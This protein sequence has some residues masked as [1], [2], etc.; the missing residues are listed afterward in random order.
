MDYKQ[1]CFNMVETQLRPWNIMSPQV[2]NVMGNT[3]REKFVPES[4][5]KIAY[6]ET[7]TPLGY[8]QAMMD[9]AV[10]GRLL[11]A[12]ELTPNDKVLE[13]G[14]GSGYLTS[15]LSQLSQHVT[16]LEIVP[17]L[18][19]LAASKL[20]E[21]TNISFQTADFFSLKWAGTYDAIVL[22]GSLPR[23]PDTLKRLLS[24]GGRLFVVIGTGKVM[25]AQ[26]MTRTDEDQWIAQKL[27]ETYL[28]PLANVP[29]IEKFQF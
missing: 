4:Y 17:E 25:T 23:I 19:D 3:P 2:L 22:S 21:A 9:P 16:S 8:G 13:V 28:N 20:S 6:T 5:Q 11:Q 29:N 18:S 27:F 14:T 7:R 26:L 10:E 1:A 15:L 12:L 24:I